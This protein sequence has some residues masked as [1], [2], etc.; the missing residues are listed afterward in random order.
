MFRITKPTEKPSKVDEIE[1]KCSLNHSLKIFLIEL[2][3]FVII[4]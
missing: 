3:P 2:K 4:G 1:F